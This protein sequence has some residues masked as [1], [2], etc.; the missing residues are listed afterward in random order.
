VPSG[1]I[2]ILLM[3]CLESLLGSVQSSRLGVCH[4]VQLGVE[5]VLGSVLE[6]VLIAYWE[7]TVKQAGSVPSSAIGS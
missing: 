6:S 4:R 3:E 7:R 2:Y 5:S 1:P